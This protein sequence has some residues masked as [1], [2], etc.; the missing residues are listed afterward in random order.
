MANEKLDFGPDNCEVTSEESG[1]VCVR[2]DP[3]VSLEE[4]KTGKSHIVSTTRGNK[5]FGVP[6]TGR[7]IHVGVKVFCTKPKAERPKTDGS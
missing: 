2:F 3:N 7:Q 4:S 5:A 6:G 1:A